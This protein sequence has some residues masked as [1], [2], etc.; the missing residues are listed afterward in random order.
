MRGRIKYPSIHF[1][2]IKMHFPFTY[3]D[4]IE[5]EWH[6]MA[7]Y[8]WHSVPR[9]QLAILWSGI[10]SLFNVNAEVSFRISLYIANFLSDDSEQADKI[11]KKVKKLYSACSTAVHDKEVKKG[12]QKKKGKKQAK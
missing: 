12:Y 7:S 3:A 1:S 2:L 4:R 8:R 9:V 5:F 10:E 11:F 6:A